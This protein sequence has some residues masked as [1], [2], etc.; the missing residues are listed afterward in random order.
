M[1]CANVSGR[2]CDFSGENLLYIG[3]FRVRVRAHANG[4]D[5][6]WVSLKF[7]PDSDGES[8]GVERSAASRGGVG[9]IRAWPSH[10]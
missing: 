9:G 3:E 4:T 1:V 7:R 8:R 5:S 10:R 2:S 6:K